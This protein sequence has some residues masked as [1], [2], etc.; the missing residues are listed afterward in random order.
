MNVLFLKWFYIYIY[1]L[2]ENTNTNAE[3]DFVC[4]FQQESE[5]DIL[6]SS[7]KLG[8]PSKN[9][10]QIE[11][12]SKNDVQTEDSSKN[13][14]QTEDSLKN[15]VLTELPSKNDILTEQDCDIQLLDVTQMPS[16]TSQ[17]VLSMQTQITMTGNI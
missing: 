6:A 9:D 11:Q 3:T 15:D 16:D 14:V 4:P 8:H 1:I 13:D 2:T 5:R 7:P 10:I 17:S 12:P